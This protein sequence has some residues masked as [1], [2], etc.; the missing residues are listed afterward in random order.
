MPGGFELGRTIPLMSCGETVPFEPI[1][2]LIIIDDTR[3][4][5]AKVV[6]ELVELL[7]NRGFK[8]QVHRIQDGPVPPMRPSR[9]K[10]PRRQGRQDRSGSG[11]ACP[12]R[13]A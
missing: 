3:G 7:A 12:R 2:L 6:P 8:P 5:C 4:W 10:G 13:H 11:A 1:P 9:A